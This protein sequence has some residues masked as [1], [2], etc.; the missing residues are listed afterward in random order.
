METVVVTGAAGSLGQRVL[1]LLARAQRPYRVVGIDRVPLAGTPAG[2]EGHVADLS[3]LPGAEEPSEGL[4]AASFAGADCVVHLAWQTASTERKRSPS[5]SANHGALVRTLRL[6]EAAGASRLVYVSSATVYGAW[7][8]NAVPLAEDAALRPNPEFVFAVE[9]AESERLLDDWAILHP[10]VAV[11]V[12]RPTVTV[13]SSGRPLYEALGGTRAPSSDDSARLVQFLHVDD[14]AVAIALAVDKSL[15]GVFN[16]APDPGIAE[17]TVRALSGGVR[18]VRLPTGIATR[19]SAWGWKS[20][21]WGMP[22]QAAPYSLHPWA[23]TSERLRAQGWRPMYNSEEALVATDTR[24][25]WDDIP[26]ARRLN[27]TLALG[28]AGAGVLCGGAIGATLWYRR[29]NSRA[30]TRSRCQFCDKLVGWCPMAMT[31]VSRLPWWRKP[32]STR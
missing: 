15:S 9:K 7:A 4:L 16:V 13:G 32:I 27:Y 2:V 3:P 24:S 17:S 11:A 6:S 25:H 30:G 8:D 12:L 19:I 28:A 14:L 22:R 18:R 20:F 26:P 31:L 21:G 10:G 5:P 1:V 23:V 29:R